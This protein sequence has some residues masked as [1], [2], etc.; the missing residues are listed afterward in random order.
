M[1]G[2][3]LEL[4]AIG[5]EDIHLIKNPTISFF[6]TSYERH[7]NFALETIRQ[8]FNSEINFGER[9]FCK[10]EPY[11]DLISD[12]ILVLELPELLPE[13]Y[14]NISTY[15]WI[16]SIGHAIIESYKI[17]IDDQTID[18]QTGEWLK[19]WSELTLSETKK[20]GYD[21]MTGLFNPS[22]ATENSGPLKLLIPLKF[23]FCKNIGLSLPI[24]TLKEKNVIISFKFRKLSECWI[25]K[26]GM[27]G[28][29]DLNITF[30]AYLL[31]DYIYLDSK[32]RIKF[33]NDTHI[34]LIEQVQSSLINMYPT[35]Q[36]S[37]LIPL[38][39]FKY[40]IKELIWVIQR[41][42]V[43]KPYENDIE[44]FDWVGGND[45]FN[46]TNNRSL[47][48]VNAELDTFN[49]ATLIFNNK[50]RFSKLPSIYFRYA[51]PLKFHS[52]IPK[53]NIYVYS[54]AL[55]PEEYEPTGTCNFSCIENPILVLDRDIKSKHV[56]NINV[57]VY[58][59]NYNI[60]ILSKDTIGLNY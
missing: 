44:D 24:I 4:I 40:P 53:S 14:S 29:P 42:D 57:K 43:V 18:S 33:I 20:K 2:G 6:K 7:T 27:E 59:T 9:V 16:D 50:K 26:I 23:W 30:N 39:I 58:A 17:D 31:I 19:I 1:P 54:F 28:E 5:N 48:D 25:K 46:Y 38:K 11:G 8:N 34:Y 52:N 51:Q 49:Y 47:L 3:L 21:R 45:W 12:I 22:R 10:L 15:S 35:H 37:L 60:L 32:E 36:T 56:T 41:L 55:K 13:S